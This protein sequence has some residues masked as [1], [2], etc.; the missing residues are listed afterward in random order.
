MVWLVPVGD[1]LCWFTRLF[2]QYAI[3]LRCTTRDPGS[4]SALTCLR[5]V[6][7]TAATRILLTCATAARLAFRMLYGL[8]FTLSRLLAHYCLPPSGRFIHRS[9]LPHHLHTFGT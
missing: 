2:V 7:A 3:L 4:A 5:T 8:P 9:V 6:C 1:C